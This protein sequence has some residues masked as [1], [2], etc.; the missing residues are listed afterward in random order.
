MGVRIID[1]RPA[2]RSLEDELQALY[3]PRPV[4]RSGPGGRSAAI[5]PTDPPCEFWPRPLVLNEWP[6]RAVSDI[7]RTDLDEEPV[8]EEPVRE[9]PVREKPVRE[10]QHPWRAEDRWCR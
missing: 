8:R 5:D 10:K 7:R 2:P 6:V 1:R 9:E 4:Y 3:P